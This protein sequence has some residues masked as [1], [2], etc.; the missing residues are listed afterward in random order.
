MLL[1]RDVRQI[2]TRSGQPQSAYQIEFRST[3]AA[4]S[5]P[6]LPVSRNSR[7]SHCLSAVESSGEQGQ[8]GSRVRLSDVVMHGEPG[9]EAVLLET[10]LK[11]ASRLL[12]SW[13]LP[14]P[15]LSPPPPPPR[16]KIGRGH[17]CRRLY[18]TR[19]HFDDAS[20][21]SADL[22]SNRQQTALMGSSCPWKS[23]IY[24]SPT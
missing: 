9:K 22:P 18:N 19:Q 10:L 15:A 1:A 3:A 14:A 5:P 8:N 6:L 17:F 23:D 21:Q 2:P 7:S 11:T 12:L 13:L 24:Y 16:L 20:R 4:W